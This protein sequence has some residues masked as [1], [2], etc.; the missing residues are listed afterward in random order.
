MSLANVER[1]GWR[2]EELSRRHRRWG[3]N[4]PGVDLDFVLVEYGLGQPAAIVEYKHHQAA[5]I[6]LQHPTYRAIAALADSA[7]I[8]FLVARYWPGV[9]SFDVEPANAL[10]LNTLERQAMSERSFVGL[11]HECRGLVLQEQVLRHLREEVVCD[12]AL[13]R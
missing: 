8:P 3:F 11:L 4:C 5:P 13:R 12:A 6:D 2:D 7:T 10:A 9:W 1:T